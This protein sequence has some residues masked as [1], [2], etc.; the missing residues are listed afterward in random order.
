MSENVSLQESE[1]LPWSH[2]RCIFTKPNFQ[3]PQ[4]LQARQATEGVDRQAVVFEIIVVEVPGA[5]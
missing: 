1:W 3:Y 4:Y 2:R 5:A